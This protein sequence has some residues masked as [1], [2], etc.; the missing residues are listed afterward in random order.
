MICN[1]LSNVA[2]LSVKKY[3]LNIQDEKE[4]VQQYNKTIWKWCRN[5]TTGATTHDCN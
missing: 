4:Q 5:G 1:S 2:Q 3:F